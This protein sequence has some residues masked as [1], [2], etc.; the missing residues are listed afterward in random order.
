MPSGQAQQ[1]HQPAQ[2]LPRP[3]T[4]LAPPPSLQKTQQ[5]RVPG[6]TEVLSQTHN[7]VRWLCGN[8]G[9]C[10][11]SNCTCIVSCVHSH[12]VMSAPH[13]PSSP[14]AAP[15]HL[16]ASLQSRPLR[17]GAR[18]IALALLPAGDDSSGRSD[19]IA[20]CLAGCNGEVSHSLNLLSLLL[21]SPCSAQSRTHW[22]CSRMSEGRAGTAS[23]ATSSGD[24]LGSF[25]HAG[26]QEE[27]AAARAAAAAAPS[28]HPRRH[29]ALG[30]CR[31]W[32]GS[33]PATL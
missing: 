2:P 3:A 6:C 8:A 20:C 22:P 29:S 1:A 12:C 17:H 7:L 14:P 28:W 26:W 23:C 24:L 31:L 9:D 18:R 5:C 19:V 32:G 33:R 27:A 4:Q 30:C 11:P 10:V 21:L 13:S 15:P 16:P 25:K